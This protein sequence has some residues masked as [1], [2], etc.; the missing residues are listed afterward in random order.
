MGIG[1]I[2]VLIVNLGVMVAVICHRGA[3]KLL[4]PRSIRTWA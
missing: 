4:N 3:C 2:S 1:L